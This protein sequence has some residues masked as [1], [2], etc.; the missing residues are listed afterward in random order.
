MLNRNIP[1]IIITYGECIKHTHRYYELIA[2][3]KKVCL[4]SLIYLQ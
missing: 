4:F 3:D 1:A 2:I